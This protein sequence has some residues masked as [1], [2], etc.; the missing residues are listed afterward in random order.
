MRV[1]VDLVAG[2][3]IARLATVGKAHRRREAL[4]AGRLHDDARGQ[5]LARQRAVAL[6]ADGDGA[7]EA[8]GREERD[9]GEQPDGKAERSRAKQRD[10]RGDEEQRAERS[11]NERGDGE[12]RG[13][14]LGQPPASLGGERRSRER[15]KT[16]VPAC[17]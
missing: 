10:E 8:A 13:G 14:N 5:V 16:W 6:R 2:D 15:Q 11:E 4:R 7:E 1:D 17:A 3:L 12:R 9:G